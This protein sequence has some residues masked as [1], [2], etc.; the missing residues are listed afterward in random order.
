MIW[1]AGNCDA[2]GGACGYSNQGA[3][4]HHRMQPGRRVNGLTN[5]LVLFRFAVLSS[6]SC[7]SLFS[8]SPSRLVRPV[9]CGHYTVTAYITMAESGQRSSDHSGSGFGMFSR[10]RGTRLSHW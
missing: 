9:H 5:Y 7:E 2:G 1:L 4:A 10:P 8:G 3:S 6:L